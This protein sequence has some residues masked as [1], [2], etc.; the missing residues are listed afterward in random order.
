MCGLYSLWF[1]FVRSCE[2][3]SKRTAEDAGLDAQKENE[4]THEEN[5]EEAEEEVE[6]EVEEEEEENRDDNETEEESTGSDGDSDASGPDDVEGLRAFALSWLE[7]KR[8]DGVP[9]QNIFESLGMKVVW[10]SSMTAVIAVGG[11]RHEIPSI[12]L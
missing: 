8:I 9:P 4:E 3:M 12:F 10:F 6:V 1:C 5:N 11:S 7:D 2:E